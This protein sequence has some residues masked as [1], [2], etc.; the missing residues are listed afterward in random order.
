MRDRRQPAKVLV[1]E[2]TSG[3]EIGAFD[4]V[5]DTNDLF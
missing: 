4:I 5:G 1:Y 2:S 3:K